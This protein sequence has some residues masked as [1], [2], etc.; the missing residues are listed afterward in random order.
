MSLLTLTDLRELAATVLAPEGPD[1]PP[2]L[3]APV[4]AIDPPALVVGWAEPWLTFNSQCFWYARLA[5]GCYAGRLEPDSG[6]ETLEGLVNHVV[7]RMRDDGYTWPFEVG[8]APRLVEYGG[9]PLLGAQVV[10]NAPVTVG[11]P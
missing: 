2:I 3:S 1:D 11:G 6:V 4:D 9:I 5:V 8:H 10:F 7:T